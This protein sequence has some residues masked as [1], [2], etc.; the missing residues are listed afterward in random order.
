MLLR[1]RTPYDPVLPRGQLNA[2]THIATPIARVTFRCGRHGLSLW[3]GPRPTKPSD[4]PL[5]GSHILWEGTSITATGTVI[6]PGIRG[7]AARVD[8]Q[9]GAMT[10]SLLVLGDRRWVKN[11]GKLVPSLAEPWETLPLSWDLAF[12]GS[13][14]ISP[15]PFGPQRLPHP[16]GRVAYAFNPHGRG[17][18]LDE[19]KAEGTLLPNIE[20]LGSPLRHPLEQPFPAGLGPCPHLPALR[21]PTDIRGEAQDFMSPN[22]LRKSLRFLHSAAG[23]QIVSHFPEGASIQLRGLGRGPMAF[24]VPPC[25]FRV[26]VRRGRTTT[27]PPIRIRDVHLDAD[28]GAV[29]VTYAAPFAYETPPSW[30]EITPTGAEAARTI[31]LAVAV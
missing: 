14:D 18:C 9:V 17:F 22:M 24:S 4:P 21:A 30:V 25:P 11:A 10:K 28:D 5:S 7:L 2:E 3:D 8:L 1:N 23:D 29:L 15:G 20:A 16:G 19:R 27:E 6:R 13:F 12:G 26:G 31:A